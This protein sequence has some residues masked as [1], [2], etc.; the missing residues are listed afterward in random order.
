MAD[1]TGRRELDELRRLL[2][3]PD[4][5]RDSLPSLLPEP[6]ERPRR[7]DWTSWLAMVLAVTA[8]VLVGVLVVR[9]LLGS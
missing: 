5:L 8:T 6:L 7:A 3:Q 9:L 4:F 1:E 2:E